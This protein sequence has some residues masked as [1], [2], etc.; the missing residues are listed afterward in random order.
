MA[1]KLN[2]AQKLIEVRKT[3]KSV[4]KDSDGYNFSYASGTQILTKIRE[5]LDEH[6]V[7]LIPNLTAPIVR[8]DGLVSSQM[9]MVWV[10]AETPDDRIECDWF[11]V[12]RQK[13]PSQ[14]FGSGLTYS[15]RYF[16]LK[17]FNIP[18]DDDDPDKIGKSKGKVEEADPFAGDYT[19]DEPKSAP[20]TDRLVTEPQL[21]RLYA[22]MKEA[23]V[24]IDK[25]DA[26]IKKKFSIEHKKQMTMTEI[27][28]VFKSLDEIIKKNS[29]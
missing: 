19:Q 6:G 12:G 15:E 23:G 9:K 26:M 28:E 4:K 5:G 24:E 27:D 20:K 13:D 3:I 8:E 18:T 10:N 29:A 21:K 22:M 1:D 16:M 14:G 17:F 11:M 25:W 7:L 2:L